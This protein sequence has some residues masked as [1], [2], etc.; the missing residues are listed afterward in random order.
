MASFQGS[1]LLYIGTTTH[2]RISFNVPPTNTACETS[3]SVKIPTIH[4]PKEEEDLF[5]ELGPLPAFSGANTWSAPRTVLLTRV[6]GSFGIFVR[7]AQPVLVSGLDPKGSAEVSD[8]GTE[9]RERCVVCVSLIG[10]GEEGGARG[11]VYWKHL[12]M[13]G[14]W[15]G[16]QGRKE[17]GGEGEGFDIKYGSMVDAWLTMQMGAMV[18][19]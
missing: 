9:A 7:G 4:P 14:L 8:Y 10:A 19:F 1:W 3:L 5:S 15:F 6:K 18:D 2:T 12:L 17:G 11:L 13:A 16:M